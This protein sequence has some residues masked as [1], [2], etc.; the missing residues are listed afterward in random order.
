METVLV[1]ILNNEGILPETRLALCKTIGFY[2]RD[3]AGTMVAGAPNMKW[4]DVINLC[5][6]YKQLE[7][8]IESHKQAIQ[9]NTR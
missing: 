6:A 8:T 2:I 1:G 3:E 9:R 7:D 4:S 5:K